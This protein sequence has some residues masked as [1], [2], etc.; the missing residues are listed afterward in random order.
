[1][2][3]CFSG[4]DHPRTDRYV[5]FQAEQLS[6]P[7]LSPEMGHA[8]FV[9]GRLRIMAGALAVWDFS[10][11]SAAFWRRMGAQ[12]SFGATLKADTT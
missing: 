12:V 1:V 11:L 3:I 5:F 9:T 6:S 8:A 7:Y 10:P 4:V 2:E